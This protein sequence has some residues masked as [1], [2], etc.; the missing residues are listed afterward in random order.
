PPINS[1]SMA[2]IAFLLLIFFLVCTTISSD[3]GLKRQL[4]NPCPPIINCDLLVSENNLLNIQINEHH[5]LMVRGDRLS[6]EQ[7]KERVI[8]FMDNN[9]ND[10][11]HYCKGKRTAS[12][13]DH[14]QKAKIALDVNP[15]STYN[16]YIKVE[17]E[18]SK[19]L[20]FLRISYAQTTFGKSIE[21]LD[22]DELAKIRDA[23]PF[24]LTDF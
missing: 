4:S 14:P 16:F 17:D 5:E 2:D 24:N 9:A 13:S 1:G 15:K 6:I 12:D 11:C 18:I 3:V 10:E 19:A 23:Y 8:K 20:K 21:N 7:L 22:N